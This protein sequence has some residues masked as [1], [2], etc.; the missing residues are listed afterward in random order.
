MKILFWLKLQYP[1]FP[2]MNTQLRYASYEK[3][4]EFY[5]KCNRKSLMDCIQEAT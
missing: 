3:V 2:V 1:H 4:F 5:L